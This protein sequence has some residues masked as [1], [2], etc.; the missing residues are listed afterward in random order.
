[1]VDL[2]EIFGK[3]VCVSVIKFHENVDL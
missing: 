2:H 3:I 1:M